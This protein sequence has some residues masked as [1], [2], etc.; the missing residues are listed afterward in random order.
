MPP[1]IV[2]AGSWRYRRAKRS[3]NIAGA[4]RTKVGIAVSFGV[5]RLSFIGTDK[6][7][8]NG[9]GEKAMPQRCHRNRCVSYST[10]VGLAL[11]MRL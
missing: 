11:T 2:A 7:C 1:T 6:L 8:R 5:S 9:A 3:R 10:E 4:V